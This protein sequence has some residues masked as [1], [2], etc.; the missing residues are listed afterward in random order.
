[1]NLITLADE[2]VVD[3]SDAASAIPDNRWVLIT[4]AII[5]AIG[6]V[7]AAWIGR[8]NRK[9]NRN[10][11]A[12]VLTELRQIKGSVSRVHRRLD[13]HLEWHA[14]HPTEHSDEWD[15][16]ERRNEPRED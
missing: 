7:W 11:H 16:T 8:A 15:G 1:M 9:E 14:G 12:H 10:D 6:S 5:A 13:D 3:V 4:V 2:A